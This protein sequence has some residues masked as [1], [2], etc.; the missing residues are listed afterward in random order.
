TS[1]VEPYGPLVL[2]C[3]RTRTQVA[4]LLSATA[5]W[6]AAGPPWVGY[7]NEQILPYCGLL[8]MNHVPFDVLLDDDVVAGRL[9]EYD[10]LIIPRGDTLTRTVHQRI[11]D[12]ASRGKKVI[13]DKSLR[14][15]VPGAA[16]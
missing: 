14:A 4:V 16:I 1:L 7:P 15:S 13:A 9:K 8:L 6:F 12:F 11:V 2:P 5:T 10:T 3:R